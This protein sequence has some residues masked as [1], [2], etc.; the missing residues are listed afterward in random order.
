MSKIE[1]GI[2]IPGQGVEPRTPEE[3]ILGNVN[4]FRRLGDL[5]PRLVPK[6]VSGNSFGLYAAAAIAGAVGLAVLLKMARDRYQLVT[7]A[8]DIR[9]QQGLGRT[10]ML[11]VIGQ[12]LSSVQN[13]ARRHHVDITNYNGPLA[14]VVGGVRSS[15]AYLSREVTKARLLG[16]EGVY[17]SPIRR[18]EKERY[19]QMLE[20]IPI[21]DPD[22]PLI[23]STNPRIIIDGRELKREFSDQLITPVDLNK[24]VRLWDEVNSGTGI[25]IDIGPDGSMKK[26]AQRIAGGHVRILALSDKKDQA[27]IRNLGA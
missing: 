2:I 18:T 9:V 16:I 12:D 4:N 21:D 20:P 14:Y 6:F 7:E 3:S 27:E 25:V 23:A 17:H 24:A 8:E 1:V 13:L 22:I 11:A 10:G 15:L 26:L 19:G 5:N